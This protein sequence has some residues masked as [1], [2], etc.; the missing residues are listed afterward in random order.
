META[1]KL[2]EMTKSP[3]SFVP[4]KLNERQIVQFLLD[5]F[6]STIILVSMG[7]VLYN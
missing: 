1:R 4:K 2:W 7:L 5:L 3:W 6:L